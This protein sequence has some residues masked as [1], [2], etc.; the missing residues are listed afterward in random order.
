MA[1][2]S[3]LLTIVQNMREAGVAFGHRF[4]PPAAHVHSELVTL[5]G[6]LGIDDPGES[7][8]TALATVAGNWHSIA[9]T[10]SGVSLEFTDPAA[11]I[12]N[13]SA[14][15]QTIK[16]SID[17]ILKAPEAA[18]AGLG[19]SGAAIKNVL[20]KRLLDFILYE[21]IVSTHPKIGGAFLLLG[22]LRREFTSAAGNA[23]LRDAEIRV[24]DLAQF[25]KALTHPRESFLTVMR[26]G[27]DDF[28]ARP[29]VDGMT[30]LLSTLPGTVRG[31]ADDELPQADEAKFTGPL[32]AGLRPSARRTLA[33]QGQTISFVGLHKRGLGLLVT[34]PVNFAGNLLPKSPDAAVFAITPGAAPASDPPGVRVLP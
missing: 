26:W 15:A 11:V 22:V 8:S 33:V 27:T 9:D 3:T 12:A 24:F 4:A 34:N 5:L 16:D 30:L 31:P 28:L 6:E 14:K 17:A 23:A 13:L 29:V 10:L 21:F 32:A 2:T 7:V 19:A 18:L 25:I 20:P 1:E